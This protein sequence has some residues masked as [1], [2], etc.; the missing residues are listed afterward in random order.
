MFV[1]Y[2]VGFFY[3]QKGIYFNGIARYRVIYVKN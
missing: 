2:L 1:K 3:V